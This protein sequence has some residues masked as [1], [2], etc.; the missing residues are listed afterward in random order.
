MEATTS[1]PREAP[2]SQHLLPLPSTNSSTRRLRSI[3]ETASNAFGLFRRYRAHQF[4]SHDPESE[5]S[6]QN[7][8]NIVDS[9]MDHLTSPNGPYPNH[10]SFRLGD[11]YWNHGIQKS[12]ASFKELVSIV[13]DAE[14]H[15]SD[16]RSTNWDKINGKLAEGD[17]A[18]GEW[19]DEEAGWTT[20]PVTISVPFHRLTQEPGPQDYTIAQFHHRSLTSVIREKLTNEND[21]LHFHYEP[22]ELL[23]QCGDKQ[24]PLRVHGELYTSAAFLDAHHALQESPSEPG[25]DLPRAIIALMFW[26][27]AT[28]LTNFGNAKLWPLY[29]FFGNESKYRRGK[30][31]CNLC[32]HVAYFETVRAPILAAFST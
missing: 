24:D 9:K 23:W 5:A 30:P 26:S 31:S 13:G 14:F 7:L 1:I 19:A 17:D 4:P 10:S 29:L 15:P 2:Q 8:S 32:E 27:D 22:Y 28:Q 12:Q 21:A 18:E 25:C 11:W 20:S 3:L 16:I 6:I